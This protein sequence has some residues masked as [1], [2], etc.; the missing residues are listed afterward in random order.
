[1]KLNLLATTAVAALLASG[2]I[3]AQ[4]QGPEHKQ[5]DKAQ[6]HQQQQ[7]G[8]AKQD[9]ADEKQARGKEGAAGQ[10]KPAQ[11]AQDAQQKNGAAHDQMNAKKDEAPKANEQ[12][13]SKK[14][15]TAAEN[16]DRKKDQSRAAESRDRAKG[17]SDKPGKDEAAKD[18]GL[19]DKKSNQAP[20]LIRRAPDLECQPH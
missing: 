4:A 14:P 8:A 5:D 13:Q 12:A 19:K 20:A 16:Q 15:D 7:K 9:R 11:H 3:Y 10:A 1:M 2:G 17:A 6:L 18:N